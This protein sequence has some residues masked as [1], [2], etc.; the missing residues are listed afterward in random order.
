[1]N[2]SDLHS[3]TSLARRLRLQQLLIFSKVVEATSVL[4]A[5]RELAMTQPAVTKSIQ[6]LE[7]Q[8]GAKL[9]LRG[10]NGMRLTE[11]GRIFEDHAKIM[12]SQLRYLAED[13]NAWKSGTAGHVIVGTLIAAS[14][15]LLPRA[16]RQLRLLAPHVVVTVR[17]GSNSTLYP[18]LSR[19]DIDIVLGILPK[20]ASVFLR[21][22]QE[23]SQLKHV[24][25]YEEGL[26][27]VVG[28]HHPLAHQEHLTLSELQAM[29][30]IIP[31][32]ESANYSVVQKF[33]WEEGLSMPDRVVETVSILTNLE[34]LAQSDMLAIMPKS[35]AQSFEKSGFIK[36]LPFNKKL[37][38]LNRIGYTIRADREHS[39]AVQNFIQALHD[40]SITIN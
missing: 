33:F 16:I 22:K 36:I 6:D 24:T 18:M 20:D 19:G 1:M 13:L 30:W 14:A 40:V 32:K 11:F 17:V 28:S 27:V 29:D 7:N 5:A 15:T 21:E 3:G 23:R 10:K 39:I 38:E 31:T 25:L 34:L 37:N 12:L 8:L 26:H 35:A 4:A 9:F 2:H